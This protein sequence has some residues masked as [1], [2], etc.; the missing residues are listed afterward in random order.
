MYLMEKAILNAIANIVEESGVI[1]YEG[2][3]FTVQN[4]FDDKSILK[5]DISADFTLKFPG[6]DI[7]DMPQNLILRSNNEGSRIRRASPL[8]SSCLMGD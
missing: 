2:M 8:W 5:Y 3:R 1:S 6:L 7:P 4:D